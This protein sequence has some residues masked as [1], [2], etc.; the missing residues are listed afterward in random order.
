[1]QRAVKQTPNTS[2]LSLFSD[3]KENSQC[4]SP[5]PVP[6]IAF[7][8]RSQLK[9]GCLLGTIQWKR[10]K[11]VQTKA[12]FFS[13]SCRNGRFTS[14]VRN[15]A[16]TFPLLFRQKQLCTF[17]LAVSTMSKVNCVWHPVSP[18]YLTALAFTPDKWGGFNRPSVQR[19]TEVLTKKLSSFLYNYLS[20]KKKQNMVTSANL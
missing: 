9:H 2:F 17:T 14:C 16:T 4:F 12:T 13:F 10:F 7:L 11:T 15:E 18:H 8:L 6:I 5:I 1:M 19:P 3:F 20:L